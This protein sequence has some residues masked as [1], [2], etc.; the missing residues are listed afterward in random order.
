[1]PLPIL[2]E[3]ETL[4]Q[5]LFLVGFDEKRQKKVRTK[6]NMSRF[7]SHYSSNPIVYAVLWSRLI[8][9]LVDDIDA[10]VSSVGIDKAIAY[11]FMGIHFLACYPT[12]EEAEGVFAK[13]IGVCDKTWS[14]QAW[15][16][17][18][19]I[20]SLKDEIITWPT[21][22]NNPDNP[23]DSTSQTT[24]I[25]TVDGVHCSIAEPNLENFDKNKKFYSHKFH[26]PGLD[27]E[28]VMSIFEQRCVHING[29]FPAGDPDISV[30]R[31]GLKQKMLDAR[32]SS[33]IDHRG[34]ADK[35]YRGKALLLSVPSS[36][37]TA[38]IREFKA[39][40]LSRH[41]TFNCRLN[42]FDCLDEKFRSGHSIEKHKQ[43]FEAVVV[44]CQLQL[45]NGSPLFCV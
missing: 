41:E 10:I 22:W 2:T 11:F 25:V 42:N 37:D 28:V 26:G 30:F 14:T 27:Y 3:E 29:P 23:L 16:Y 39:R 36:Q 44:I 40:A 18:G 31:N 7:R 38:A 8:V 15:K 1:M 34:I 4:F 13:S 20:C 32:I 12:E 33:G 45:E 35:G 9:S 19:L 5:G 6:K 17:A 24:F 43:C 21:S